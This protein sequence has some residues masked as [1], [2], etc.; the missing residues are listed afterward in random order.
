MRL[1]TVSSIPFVNQ[2]SR[3]FLVLSAATRHSLWICPIISITTDPQQHPAK[4]RQ[5]SLTEPG[6]VTHFRW[7]SP[8][9]LVVLQV[10]DRP[11]SLMRITLLDACISITG[12]AM[13]TKRKSKKIW[14][15]YQSVLL[16]HQ[17]TYIHAFNPLYLV[18][19]SSCIEMIWRSLPWVFLC[20]HNNLRRTFVCWRWWCLSRGSQKTGDQ[21]PELYL[22]MFPG[23]GCP[24][25]DQ[26]PGR[27]WK[28][29]LP[30]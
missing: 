7:I 17:R 15:N 30:L 18:S 5:K 20:T 10:R 14:L 4:E 29:C 6:G 13:G 26:S 27:R 21:R 22:N 1:N 12:G 11:S 24:D 9:T 23:A 28:Q 8:L 3:Q 25:L 19:R 16:E 2:I